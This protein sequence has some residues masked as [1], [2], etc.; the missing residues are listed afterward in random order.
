MKI[1]LHH[2]E[3]VMIFIKY[4]ETIFIFNQHKFKEI[5]QQ[6]NNNL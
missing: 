3:T 1:L 2:K 6:Y 5:Q 4:I